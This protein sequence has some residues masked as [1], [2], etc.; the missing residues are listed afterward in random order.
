MDPSSAAEFLELARAGFLADGRTLAA[1]ACDQ[2]LAVVDASSAR[3]EEA[4]DRATAAVVAYE[5]LRYVLRTPT[6]RTR[7][8]SSYAHTV[9]LALDLCIE[10]DDARAAAELIETARSQAVLDL[11]SSASAGPITTAIDREAPTARP[12]SADPARILAGLDPSAAPPSVVVGGR[13]FM[14]AARGGEGAVVSLDE[15]RH[16]LGGADSWWWSS[17]AGPTRLW[18][19][20][21]APDTIEAGAIDIGPSSLAGQA[22]RALA[23][24]LPIDRGE[25]SAHEITERVLAGP[26]AGPPP[27]EADLARRLGECL[28]PERLRAELRRRA[29]SGRPLRLVVAPAPVIASVP[30]ATLAVDGGEPRRAS[31]PTRVIEGADVVMVPSVAFLAAADRADARGGRGPLRLVVADPL[32]DL[33]HARRSASAGSRPVILSGPAATL[34]AVRAAIGRL[35]TRTNG[36][37]AVVGHA[38]ASALDDAHL[39]LAAEPGSSRCPLSTTCGGSP[40]WARDVLSDRDGEQWLGGRVPARVLLSTCRSSGADLAGLGGEWQGLAPAMIWAGA[41]VVVSTMW[42]LVDHPASARLDATIIGLLERAADPVGAL[43]EVLR[44]QLREWRSSGRATSAE[45]A[46]GFGRFADDHVP[47]LIWAAF[48]VVGAGRSV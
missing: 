8:V 21:I 44:D 9:A 17:W 38:R 26:L 43:A 18:W 15:A 33:P 42:P 12:G 39:C 2:Q 20:L 4:F 22:L 30:L 29:R 36:V 24:A 5:D 47:P 1:A 48:V 25:E 19:A 10:R 28:L 31:E 3:Y 35:G 7:W 27:A 34:G 37:M 16:A 14:R 32:G 41:E 6:T 11:E 45:L 13:S 40:L 46:G 23:D